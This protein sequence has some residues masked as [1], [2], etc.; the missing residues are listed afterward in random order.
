M[1]TEQLLKCTLIISSL[2]VLVSLVR[3]DLELHLALKGFV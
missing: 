3:L 1:E 2:T